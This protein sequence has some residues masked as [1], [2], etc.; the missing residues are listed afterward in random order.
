MSRFSSLNNGMLSQWS[1]W[2]SNDSRG[3]LLQV[4]GIPWDAWDEAWKIPIWWASFSCKTYENIVG[5]PFIGLSIQLIIYGRYLVG[6]WKA[7][8]KPYENLGLSPTNIHSH[9]P[10]N[11]QR[12]LPSMGY[13][14]L[15]SICWWHF[16]INMNY[17]IHLGIAPFMETSQVSCI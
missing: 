11:I 10:S 6:L 16:P 12:R 5:P 7:L 4:H 1:P 8:W 17:T 13:P 9:H 14:Q 2:L 15:S 3:T